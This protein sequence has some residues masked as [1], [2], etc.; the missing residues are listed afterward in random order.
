MGENSDATRTYR[1]VGEGETVKRGGTLTQPG[2]PFIPELIR[3]GSAALMAPTPQW[4]DEAQ[5]IYGHLQAIRRFGRPTMGQVID[6]DRFPGE[7]R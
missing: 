1:R 3:L 7:G 4:Q 5:R 6:F 2:T